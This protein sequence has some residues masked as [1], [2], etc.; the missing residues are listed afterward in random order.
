[1]PARWRAARTLLG[2]GARGGPAVGTGRRP[3]GATAVRAGTGATGAAT[4]GAGPTGAG[5]AGSARAAGAAG[6]P[7]TGTTRTGSTGH[8]RPAPRTLLPA[9]ATARRVHRPGPAGRLRTGVPP[10]GRA[11]LRVGLLP[12]GITRVAAV[13]C[14]MLAAAVGPQVR[15]VVAPP[16]TPAVPRRAGPGRVVAMGVLARWFRHPGTPFTDRH[17]RARRAGR[18]DPGTGVCTG[19]GSG[20]RVTREYLP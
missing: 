4:G 18:R 2:S 10:A 12:A 6:P 13:R 3:L 15:A 7:G 1:M 14:R 5:A 16:G 17:G 20:A 11:G 19:G 9:T 8:P